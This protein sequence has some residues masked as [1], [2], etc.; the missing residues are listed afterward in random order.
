MFPTSP[1]D[2]VFACGSSCVCV[3]VF[4]AAVASSAPGKITIA[5]FIQRVWYIYI[6]RKK[7]RE[8]KTTRSDACP[9]LQKKL[10]AD[11][12]SEVKSRY[13]LAARLR[14]HESVSNR[15]TFLNDILESLDDDT[16]RHYP[17]TD[18]QIKTTLMHLFRLPRANEGVDC[19][20]GCSNR[21]S[22]LLP[23]SAQTGAVS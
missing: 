20:V 15:K 22:S 10:E 14:G 6:Y 3:C 4:A 8:N 18:Q 7:E 23:Q 12:I 13:D 5:I 19:M 9:S 1:V 16:L 21:S 11:W 2:S 17:P